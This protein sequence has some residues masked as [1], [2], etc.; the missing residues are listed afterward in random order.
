MSDSVS[1]GPA[2]PKVLDPVAS[3][4]PVPVLGLE[5]GTPPEPSEPGRVSVEGPDTV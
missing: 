5:L 4:M 2:A 1:P 3:G